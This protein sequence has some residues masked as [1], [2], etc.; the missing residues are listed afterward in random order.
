MFTE[1]SHVPP[2]LLHGGDRQFARATHRLLGLRLQAW[3]ICGKQQLQNIGI[4][5]LAL[6]FPHV[7]H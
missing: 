3:Y 2:H 1:L 6:I 7:A 4:N 5:K